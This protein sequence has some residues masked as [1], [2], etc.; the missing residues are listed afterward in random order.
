MSKALL[1]DLERAVCQRYPELAARLRAGLPEDDIQKMLQDAG[2]SGEVKPV[3]SLFAWHD[4]SQPAPWAT[5]A[6]ASL[7]PESIYVFG[8]LATMIEHFK[9]FQESFIFHPRHHELHGRYFPMFWDNS[10]GYL[11]VDLTSATGRM[12]LLEPE[13]E[14]LVREAYGSFDEF[15]KDAIRANEAHDILTCFQVS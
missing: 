10:T 2:A 4:G 8:D 3:V 7:F 1:H 6:D 13:S 11:A 9:T 5:L 14:E 12:V 15:L